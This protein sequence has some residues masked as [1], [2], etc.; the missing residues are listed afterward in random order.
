MY[1]DIETVVMMASYAEKLLG[2]IASLARGQ[3]PGSQT[4]APKL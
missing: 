2:D 4:G 3:R 1:L